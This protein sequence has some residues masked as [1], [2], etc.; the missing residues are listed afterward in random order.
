M[1]YVPQVWSLTRAELAWA[2]NQLR[3]VPGQWSLDVVRDP[4]E[5]SA[6][7]QPQEGDRFAPTFLLDRLLTGYRLV[8][9]RWD[10]VEPATVFV[11]LAEALE[12]VASV[13]FAAEQA[14]SQRL[15]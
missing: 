3:A 4:A 15:Q 13:A 1:A 14:G 8:P 7:L 5:L 12:H 11:T 10:E 9:C 6:V 2:E